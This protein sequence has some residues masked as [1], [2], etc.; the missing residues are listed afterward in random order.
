MKT[1]FI[2]QNSTHL[3]SVNSTNSYAIELLRQTRFPEGSLFY[4]FEQILGRGQRGNVWE[5][6]PNKNATLSIVLYPSFLPPEKQFLLT[7]IISIAVADL[8]AELLREYCTSS[9]IKIK[10]PNDI[11]VGNKK[12]AGILIEY[13]LR[14]NTIQ[15]SVI[16]IGININQL[17]FETTTCATSLALL[18]TKEFDL[19]DCIARLCELVEARY[20][21]LKANK[22]NQLAGDYLNRFY[23]LNEWKKYAA[24]NENFN[25]KIIGVSAQGMLQVQLISDEIKEFDLKEIVFL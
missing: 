2:G 18:A 20:L 19:M 8:M 14:E 12:I 9:D 5:S 21:Q 7:K 17:T 24:K 22:I 25:G 23:Q 13:S 11:Y 4:T 6:F 10:W 16:G 15:S 3:K 1:L